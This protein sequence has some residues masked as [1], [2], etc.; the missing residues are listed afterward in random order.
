M[1]LSAAIAS[2]LSLFFYQYKCQRT[3]IPNKDKELLIHIYLIGLLTMKKLLSIILISL[4]S[5][6]IAIAD[7]CNGVIVKD[8][9]IST[10]EFIDG[11]KAKNP[12][13]Y[14]EQGNILSVSINGND[15][16]FQ[17]TPVRNG[18]WTEDS[19]MQMR[20]GLI[21]TGTARME[22]VSIK[23]NNKMATIQLT[24]QADDQQRVIAGVDCTP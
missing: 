9:K 12:L 7:Q 23:E 24:I 20:T 18:E 11:G 3:I 8:T 5:S 14:Q 13:V 6:G 1:N 22:L 4:F 21:D 16:D 17:T 2:I 19:K 15:F 10:G